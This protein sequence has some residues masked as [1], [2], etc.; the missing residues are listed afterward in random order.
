M[1]IEEIK[2]RNRGNTRKICKVGAENRQRET[3]TYM[4]MISNRDKSE[5]RA[6]RRIARWE[7]KLQKKEK[8]LER[9]C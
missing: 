9:I 8:S 3:Q 7:K 4:Y 6:S 5:V 1:G 2:K